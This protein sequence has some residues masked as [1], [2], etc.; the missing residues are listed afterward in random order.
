[1]KIEGRLTGRVAAHLPVDRVPF[2]DVQHARGERLDRGV[3]AHAGDTNSLPVT[4]RNGYDEAKSRI[5]EAI[6]AGS[7]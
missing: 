3:L 2:S 7:V 1:M 5:T 4:D 6:M